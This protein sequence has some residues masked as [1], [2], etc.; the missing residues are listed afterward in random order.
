[1][2]FFLLFSEL[3][4]EVCFVGGIIDGFLYF[5]NILWV[6]GMVSVGGEEFGD[7]GFVRSLFINLAMFLDLERCSNS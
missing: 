1:M 3:G 4:F 6:L 5:E 7:F 2:I